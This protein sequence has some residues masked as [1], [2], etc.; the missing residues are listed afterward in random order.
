MAAD[1]AAPGIAEVT[2]RISI[3]DRTGS[4]ATRPDCQGKNRYKSR[5]CKNRTNSTTA[6]S[7]P[8]R[9]FCGRLSSCLAPQGPEDLLACCTLGLLAV[10]DGLGQREILEY[11]REN[12]V[13]QRALLLQGLH[14]RLL[15]CPLEC[16]SV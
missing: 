13:E 4:A 16:R 12:L 9:S 15:Q 2:D 7:G 1:Q 11:F 10:T 5:R 3:A 14:Q 8:A 6:S